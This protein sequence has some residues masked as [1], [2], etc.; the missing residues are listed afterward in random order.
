MRGRRRGMNGESENQSKE[1]REVLNGIHRSGFSKR[2][3]AAAIPERLQTVKLKA[4]R[5]CHGSTLLDSVQ[6]FGS[7]LKA[8][9]LALESDGS[10]ING[11]RGI[12]HQ[13]FLRLLQ[14]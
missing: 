10:R 2:S 6:G 7:P 11:Q 8:P 5:T 4:L 9:D 14:L 1:Q 3:S 13:R 12:V